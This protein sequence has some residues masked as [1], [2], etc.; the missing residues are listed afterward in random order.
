MIDNHDREEIDRGWQTVKIIWSVMLVS[1]FIYL[2]IAL[3]VR[4]MVEISMEEKTMQ[5]LRNVLYAVSVIVMMA[6]KYIRDLTLRSSGAGQSR[7]GSVEG[8][9]MAKYTTTTIVSLAMAESIAIFGLVLFLLGKNTTDLY[10][11]IFM[12]LAAMIYYRP[13]KEEVVNLAN[14]LQIKE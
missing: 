11:L 9:V 7:G 2:L 10:V 4:D 3:Y 6:I 5:M 13:K 12:S 14:T 1:P 8:A